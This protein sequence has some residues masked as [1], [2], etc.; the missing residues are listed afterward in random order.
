MR[1]GTDGRTAYG[2]LHG[3]ESI[4]NT[5][6]FGENVL[7][8]VPR[9]SRGKLDAGWRYGIFVGRSSNSDPKFIASKDGTVIRARAMARCIPEV[10]WDLERALAVKM[11]PLT[12][13]ARSGTQDA[14]EAEDDPHD[15][16]LPP[17]PLFQEE[18]PPS[19]AAG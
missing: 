14:I 17:H 3:K 16:A 9:R 6:E 5:C 13:R 1:L 19:P 12:E 10:R 2:R 8:Y 18:K 11:T 4:H 7:W 15:H